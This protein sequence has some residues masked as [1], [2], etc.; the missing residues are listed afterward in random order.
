MG[1]ED[2]SLKNRRPDIFAQIN[3]ELTAKHCPEID[4]DTIS[5]GSKKKL[6]WDCS[7]DSE[8]VWEATIKHRTGPGTACPFCSGSRVM[9]GNNDLEFLNPDLASQWH[10]TKNGNL[11]PSHVTAAS[12]KKVWWLCE[13][14]LRHEWETSVKERHRGRGCP[15]CSSNIIVRG[16]NDLATTR[17][18]LASEWNY[19][20]NY[21]LTPHHVARSANKKAWW[22]CP[23]DERHVYEASI[24]GRDIHNY[25]CSVCDGKT[26]IQGINDAATRYPE[27]VA[28]WHPTLN[29]QLKFSEVA[30]MSHKLA[31]WVCKTNPLHEWKTKISARALGAGCLLCCGQKIVPGINDL[32]TLY[33]KLASQWHPTLNR[34]VSP[35]S[36]SPG[37][38]TKYWWQCEK[39]E[40]HSWETTPNHRKGRP[41][42]LGSDCP[43]CIIFKTERRFRELFN[44]MADLKFV[45]G[46]VPVKWSKRNFTQIDILNEENK[47]CIEYDG[48]WSHGGKWRS[49][50]SE[51]ECLARDVRKTEALLSEGYSVIR[52]RESGLADVPVIS[53]SFFQIN[54]SLKEDKSAVAKQCIDFLRNIQLIMD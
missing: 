4:L 37:T 14:D 32:A 33:P 16:I 27:L 18:E 13:I 43:K 53:D 26:V 15:V 17:P 52:I 25:G 51:A 44:E 7:K 6:W 9:A 46:R 11:L 10:P 29:G 31:W 23:K 49:G 50:L 35:D 20:L 39:D 24:N 12:T 5:Y 38:S 54:C 2:T 28:E 47:I 19:K 3:H 8:H 30:P 42:K 36:V 48:L 41:T 22:T 34:G 45:D 21:P 1:K 40:T